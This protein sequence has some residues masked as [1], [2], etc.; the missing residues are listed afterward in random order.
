[1][2]PIPPLFGGDI[3]QRAFID[4][5]VRAA[6]FELLF[7]IA[8]AFRHGTE[9]GKALEPNQ[10]AAWAGHAAASSFW[11]GEIKM[12]GGWSAIHLLSVLVLALVLLS[13]LAAR[14]QKI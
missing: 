12:R 3:K 8:H 2:H 11:I 4:M 10:N 7:P 5:W 9:Y 1:M 14:S 6:E 13:I